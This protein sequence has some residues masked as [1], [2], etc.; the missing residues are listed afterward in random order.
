[1]KY[2]WKKALAMTCVAALL[3]GCG[4]TN[5]SSGT[6]ETENVDASVAQGSK[7]FEGAT[8]IE[9]SDEEITVDGSVISTDA[10]SAVYAANDI[11]FYLEGQDFTYGEGEEGDEHSQAEADAHTVVYITEPGT[12]A[13]SGKLSAGQIAIDLGDDAEEN[14]EAVVNLILN[15]VDITCSVAPA[16]IFYNVYECAS[17]DTEDASK[18]VDTTA[19]GANVLIADG[20]VNN[21]DGAYVARIYKPDSVELSEDGTEVLDAKKLHKY[22]GAFYSKMT[23]NVNGDELGNGVLN[24]TASNEGLDS[25][26]HLT[27]NGGNINIVS[28]NDGINTNEDE[29]S[30]T[31]INGGTLKIRVS[32]ATGEGDGIDSNGWLVINGGTVITEACSISADAGIDSDMG[33]HINGGTVIA[34]GNMLD[35]ISESAQNYAVFS[36]AASQKGGATY[37]LKNEAGEAVFTCTPENDFT[38]LILSSDALVAGTYSLWQGE[39]QLAASSGNMMGGFGGGFGGQKPDGMEMQEGVQ[40]PDGAQLPEGEMNSENGEMPEGMYRPEDG[41]MPDMQLPEGVEKPD[42]I[43]RPVEGDETAGT[44]EQTFDMAANGQM[45]E[46]GMQAPDGAQQGGFGG[47]RGQGSMSGNGMQMNAELS[48]EIVIVDGGNYFSNVSVLSE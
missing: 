23:M 32:G 18:D 6:V 17:S 8:V 9:L 22:D 43:G 42:G 26:L 33:I 25:E 31:T 39:N 41:E 37:T 27:I 4:Q 20:S 11:V 15:G 7:V 12:Y 5:N 10:E 48:A 45:P 16:V 36:F 19:A 1:M 35:Q 38:Y 46:E 34:T 44:G 21:V 14:P 47:G 3:V 13:V 28:G 2:F 24:I 29:V 30:V 40:A